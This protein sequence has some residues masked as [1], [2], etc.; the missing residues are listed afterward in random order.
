MYNVQEQTDV[1]PRRFFRCPIAPENGA[2][3]IKIG[4]GRVRGCVIEKS[5]TGYTMLLK[6]RY[7]RRM[8][9]GRKFHMQFDG[10]LMQVQLL[11]KQNI[12][13]S[14]TRLA[15][16]MSNDYTP[17]QKV[18]STCWHALL[19]SAKPGSGSTQL[20]FAGFAMVLFCVLSL[21]GLGDKLGTAEPI[22]KG[23]QTV[24]QTADAQIGALS[25]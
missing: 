22:Q 12:D 5:L 6:R 1:D 19:P 17:P 23:F 2:A 15:L 9:I 3:T 16:V 10:A 11:R 18:K 25:K 8:K 13:K 7:A 20:A 14:C 21:P 4:F 24:L